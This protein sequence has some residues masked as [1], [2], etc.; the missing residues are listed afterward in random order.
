[1]RSNF[2]YRSQSCVFI[3]VITN[4]CIYTASIALECCH[5]YVFLVFVIMQIDKEKYLLLAYDRHYRAMTG[6]GIV[7]HYNPNI[8]DISEISNDYLLSQQSSETYSLTV[9]EILHNL[10]ELEL[11]QKSGCQIRSVFRPPSSKVSCVAMIH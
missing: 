7:D 5:I 3:I 9:Q 10:S 2:K 1:M 8:T 11:K 4:V 6:S